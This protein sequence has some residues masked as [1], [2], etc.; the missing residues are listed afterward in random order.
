MPNSTEKLAKNTTARH[1]TILIYPE[2]VNPNFKDILCKPTMAFQWVLSPLHDKDLNDDGT[3]KKPHYHLLLVFENAVRINIILEIC[4]SINAPEYAEQIRGGITKFYEYLTHKNHPNKAQYNQYNESD[5]ECSNGF[6]IKDYM[7]L[8]ELK[9]LDDL[10]LDEIFDFIERNEIVSFRHLL[11]YSKQFKPEWFYLLKHQYTYFITQHIKS[12]AWE[13]L[14][15]VGKLNYS[16][17]K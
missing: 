6:D 12:I 11:A 13:K 7:S 9:K 5:I 1:W 15:G 17:L 4:R 2:S 8:K 3:L 10:I 16:T 14:N